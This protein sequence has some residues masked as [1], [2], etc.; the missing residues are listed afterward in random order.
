MEGK[1]KQ[2]AVLLLTRYRYA[3]LVLL[4]GLGLMLIPKSPESRAPAPSEPREL[5]LAQQL[6]RILSSIDGAGRVRVLLTEKCGPETHY[7]T[8]LRTDS[9]DS[10]QSEESRTVLVEEETRR[11]TGLVRRQDPPRFLGAVIS[12]QGAER[13]QVRLQIIRAAQC[14]LGL[15]SDQ[16]QVV[17]MK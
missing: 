17:T 1:L 2:T 13:P 7:Q 16:I 12:C 3:A 6:E 14:A 10:G 11:R 9:T 5:P 15:R 4:L 8:D